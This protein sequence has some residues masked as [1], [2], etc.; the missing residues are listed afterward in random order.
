MRKHEQNKL[1]IVQMI[2]AYIEKRLYSIYVESKENTT[3]YSK[4]DDVMLIGVPSLVLVY[5]IITSN[6]SIFNQ[7]IFTITTE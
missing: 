1:T 3:Y 7:A 4:T 5:N 2:G 6:S